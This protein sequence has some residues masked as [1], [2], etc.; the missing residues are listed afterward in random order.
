[1]VQIKWKNGAFRDL[2]THPNVVAELEKRGQAI[3]NAADGM[4]GGEHAV[5]SSIS[6]GRGRARTVIVA[7]DAEAQRASQKS[8]TLRRALDAGR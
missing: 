8:D 1:M 2:R 6:G 3:K 7:A 5:H 4:S